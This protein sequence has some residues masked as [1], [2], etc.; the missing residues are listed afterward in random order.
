MDFEGTLLK[1]VDDTLIRYADFG[2]MLAPNET[3]VSATASLATGSIDAAL[4]IG[5]PVV[6]V[7]D[8]TVPTASGTRIISADEGVSYALTGGTAIDADAEP[9]RIK[10]AATLSTG[11]IAVRTARLRVCE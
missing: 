2:P 5:T 8:T 4:T 7:A 6:L 11:K 9:I 1:H 3:V 10:I